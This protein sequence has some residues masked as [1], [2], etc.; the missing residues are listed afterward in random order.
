MKFQ[1]KKYIMYGIKGERESEEP[2][3]ISTAFENI[4]D[5]EVVKDNMNRNKSNSGRT[6]FVVKGIVNNGIFEP[7][8]D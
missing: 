6:Y 1:P 3:Y 8:I 5:A 4:E 7:D 2:T